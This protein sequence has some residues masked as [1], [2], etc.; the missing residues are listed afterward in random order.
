MKVVSIAKFRSNPDIV[1]QIVATLKEG[2]IACLP[3][4]SGYRLMADLQSDRPVMALLQAK[5]RVKNA[6]AL[7]LLP[8]PAG[9]DQVAKEIGRAH[10]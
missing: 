1:L 5:R 10:V 3:S 9:V 6:P 2:G 8:D 7:V 4:P